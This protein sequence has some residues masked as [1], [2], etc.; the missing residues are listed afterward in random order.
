[1][2]YDYIA[3]VLGSKKNALQCKI[4][5]NNSTQGRYKGCNVGGW[6]PNEVS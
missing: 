6:S 3:S 2:N 4:R 1:M 5:W